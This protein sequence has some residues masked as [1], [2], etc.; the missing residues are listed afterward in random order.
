MLRIPNV[1][2]RDGKIIYEVPDG[3]VIVKNIDE[4]EKP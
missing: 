4:T 2:G 3:Q 1:Y